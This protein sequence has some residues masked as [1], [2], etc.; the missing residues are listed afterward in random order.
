MFIG[1]YFFKSLFFSR[2]ISI[3]ASFSTFLNSFDLLISLCSLAYLS[4]SFSSLSPPHSPPLSLYFCRDD[5]AL[6]SL[7]HMQNLKKLNLTGNKIKNFESFLPLK[8]LK[9]LKFLELRGNSI[10][11]KKD[12]P[13]ALFEILNQVENI[14]TW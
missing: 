13:R 12:F 4:T 6:I 11:T 3:P 9:N 10:C 14:D 8:K 5:D 1:I 2:Y 7:S